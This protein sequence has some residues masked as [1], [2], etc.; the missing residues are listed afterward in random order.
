MIHDGDRVMVCL[1]GGKDSL[2]LLHTLHQYQY[3]SK[4]KVCN[5]D[6]VIRRPAAIDSRKLKQTTTATPT[7]TSSKK[8]FSKTMAVHVRY[9]PLYISLIAVLCTA[10]TRNDYYFRVFFGNARLRVVPL[11]LSPSCV[12]VFFRV[13]HDGLNERGTTR[14][15]GEHV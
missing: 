11:S 2:S 9:K 8:R 7:R 4:S 15:F 13:M 6:L 14:S 12:T 3:Y 5:P 1:S 10:T